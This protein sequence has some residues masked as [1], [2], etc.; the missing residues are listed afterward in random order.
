[1]GLSVSAL[2]T[3]LVQTLFGDPGWNDG[4]ARNGFV[5]VRYDAR[6]IRKIHGSAALQTIERDGY[7]SAAVRVG[8]FPSRIDFKARCLGEPFDIG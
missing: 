3:N 4:L 7:I 1:M 5:R 2:A 6:N 8:D